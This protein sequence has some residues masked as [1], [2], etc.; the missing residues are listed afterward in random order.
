[1]IEYRKEYREKSTKIN[2]W[3]E[4]SKVIES[5]LDDK[6]TD[7]WVLE[8]FDNCFKKKT[9]T[10]NDLFKTIKTGIKGAIAKVTKLDDAKIRN[11]EKQLNGYDF[12]D[13]KGNSIHNFGTAEI[14]TMFVSEANAK[15]FRQI[16]DD[17]DAEGVN[18]YAELHKR[19][20]KYLESYFEYARERTRE[21]QS[22]R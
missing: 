14:Q 13:E 5:G 18:N 3:E 22:H 11:Y 4:A 8:Q 21:N 17:M 20:P 16:A 9:F 6:S 7:A 2:E 12:T 1:M 10:L 15:T 19:K